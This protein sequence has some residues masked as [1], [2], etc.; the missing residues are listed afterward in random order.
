M[1]RIETSTVLYSD[2]NKNPVANST[3]LAYNL[4]AIKQS[5]DN[6]F[7]TPYGTRAWQP[8]YGNTFHHLLG[9]LMTEETTEL[10]FDK[11]IESVS[12]HEPRVTIDR[13]NSVVTAFYEQNLYRVLLVF[14]VSGLSSNDKFT[15]DIKILNSK[16]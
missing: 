15:Y 10:F 3:N 8:T 7:N 5:L 6:L 16:D 2:L 4:E 13:I 1:Q 12:L 14:T 9:E 11:V